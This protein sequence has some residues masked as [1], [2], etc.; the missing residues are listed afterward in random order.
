MAD[1]YI[2]T[3]DFEKLT[4]TDYNEETENEYDYSTEILFPVKRSHRLPLEESNIILFSN[5]NKNSK[6][7]VQNNSI[8]EYTKDLYN[9]TREHKID[10]MYV[11]YGLLSDYSENY[12]ELIGEQFFG[13]KQTLQGFL[14]KKGWFIS[15]EETVVFVKSI[16]CPN[17]GLKHAS[18]VHEDSMFCSSCV[19]RN[20]EG[21]VLEVFEEIEFGFKK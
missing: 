3:E 7:I 17:C 1:T 10:D 15:P 8:F 13:K 19:P 21:D 12:K 9:T 14:K 2:N 16:R 5:D 20:E 6:F 11:N 4:I 18:F